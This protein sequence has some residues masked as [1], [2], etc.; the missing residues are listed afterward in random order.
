[1]ELYGKIIGTV[2][3]VFIIIE[4]THKLA[5]YNKLIDN[6]IEIKTKWVSSIVDAF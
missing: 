3:P 6:S 5:F 1:M 4:D 2:I